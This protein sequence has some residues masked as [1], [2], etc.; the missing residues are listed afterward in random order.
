MLVHCFICLSARVEFKFEFE[1]NRLSSVE[2]EIE[3]SGVRK[4]QTISNQPN[5]PTRSAHSFPTGPNLSASPARHLLFFP[6]PWAQQL[7]WPS[8]PQPSKLRAFPSWLTVRATDREWPTGQRCFLPL[9]FLFS[10]SFSFPI[11]NQLKL[12][13]FAFKFKFEFNPSTQTKRTMHQHECDN[14]L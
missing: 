7:A 10:I 5:N 12:K 2:I 1:F 11:S 6:S 9:S 8:I 13:L 14:K 4:T 3:R